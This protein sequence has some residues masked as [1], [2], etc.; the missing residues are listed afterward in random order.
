MAMFEGVKA[1]CGE[2][3]VVGDCAA[4]ILKFT[5]ANRCDL[6][7]MRSHGRSALKSLLL[8]F[9]TGKVLVGC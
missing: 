5:K 3:V 7:I 8:G 2:H 9:V 6:V 4:T 1:G